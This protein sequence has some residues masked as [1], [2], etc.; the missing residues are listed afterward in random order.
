MQSV[1]F[2]FFISLDVRFRTFDVKIC[3]T[4]YFMYGVS[5]EGKYCTKF[6][7][8]Y[9]FICSKF[10]K[11][12]RYNINISHNKTTG[13]RNSF[14]NLNVNYMYIKPWCGPM[15]SK[16]FITNLVCYAYFLWF[17]SPEC[18]YIFGKQTGYTFQSP[19]TIKTWTTKHYASLN[20]W[21]NTE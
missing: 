15:T 10:Y 21:Y 12:Y 8:H 7:N 1:P 14:N 20:Q 11:I 3:V 2:S 5:H 17:F 6:L 19:K 4:S 18:Q 16:V 13:L 9:S